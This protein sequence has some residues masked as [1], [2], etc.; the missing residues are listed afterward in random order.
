MPPPTG[1]L[2][3]RKLPR[4]EVVYVASSEDAAIGVTERSVRRELSPVRESI[5]VAEG[6]RLSGVDSDESGAVQHS[7]SGPPPQNED[8]AMEVAQ[9]LVRV[10]N[11]RLG[12]AWEPPRLRPG[13]ED[14]TDC[15]A[16]GPNGQLSIQVTRAPSDES[17]WRDLGRDGRSQGS[18]ST[19]ELSDRLLLSIHKKG[20]LAGRGDVILAIDARFDIATAIPA[21]VENFGKRHAED[22]KAVGFASI[23]LVGPLDELC[24]RLA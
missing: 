6:A 15:V 12:D 20:N 23:W 8:G 10:L 13:Q 7:M 4:D 22:A 3:A 9:T 5:R 19:E 24:F 14:G 11:E 18:G 21:V 2:V 1:R 17:V 16:A